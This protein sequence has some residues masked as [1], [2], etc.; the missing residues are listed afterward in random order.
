MHRLRCAATGATESERAT[1]RERET[2]RERGNR[3]SR[4]ELEDVCAV[5]DA[6]LQH[7]FHWAVSP[8]AR[9]NPHH[10]SL[11]LQSLALLIEHRRGGRG[12][13]HPLSLCQI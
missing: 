4:G 11:L 2:E 10:L 13:P 12:Y 1:E 8:L 7:S 3:L 5:N 6:V 9:L